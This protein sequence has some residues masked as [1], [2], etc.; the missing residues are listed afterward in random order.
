MAFEEIK[1][2][3]QD[4]IGLHT[5][6]IGDASIE[7]AIKQ[8]MENLHINDGKNYLDKL[9][10]DHDEL[11]ELVEEVVVPETWF[12]RNL[13]PFETMMKY[14]K[15]LKS[16]E[17]GNS[18]I[19]ILSIPCSTG[20]EPYS[21]AITLLKNGISENSFEIDAV[22]ISKEALSK[23]RCGI[24]GKHSFRETGGVP[25]TGYFQ[26]TDSGQQVLPLVKKNVNFIEG[27]ILK[28]LIAPEP[29]YYDIIFCRNLLIYFNRDTQKI[30]LE[31]LNTILK[32]NGILF[33]G[34][35]ETVG[36]GKNLFTHLNI[37]NSFAYK[38]RSMKQFVL[39]DDKEN[40]EHVDDLKNIY[41][42]LIKVTLKDLE[43]SNKYR[44]YANKDDN[45]IEKSANTYK[46][47]D[48]TGVEKLVEQGNY[49]E[50]Y[51]LCINW[52]DENPEGAKGYYL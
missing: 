40:I 48:L 42:Q 2:L 36:A 43:L 50:A 27:N 24:Y 26:E 1:V 22:D 4:N 51:S 39:G 8:R 16:K 46:D 47:D 28:D 10:S 52:L 30:V 41:N 44:K 18:I 14:V 33:M 6:S 37:P 13:V 25:E 5:G 7:R 32:K 35:A 11:N 34:H 38:K 49:S 3:L 45:K 20:E 15:E 23:A 29:E 21:I 9:L 19:R 17:Q 12:F 31:K